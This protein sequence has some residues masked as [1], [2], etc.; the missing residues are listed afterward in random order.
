M[1]AIYVIKESTLKNTHKNYKMIATISQQQHK[2]N[3]P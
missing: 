2:T 1:Y 3:Q